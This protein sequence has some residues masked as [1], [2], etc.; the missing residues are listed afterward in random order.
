MHGDPKALYPNNKP[1]VVTIESM[2]VH[3]FVLDCICENSHFNYSEAWFINSLGV[4]E[5]H[6][7]K[8][9]TLQS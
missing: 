1:R 8:A 2:R 4:R 9:G 3:G 7:I 6:F 5:L